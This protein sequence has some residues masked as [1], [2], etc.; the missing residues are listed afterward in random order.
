MKVAA[1]TKQGKR[2]GVVVELDDE[3]KVVAALKD[4]ASSWS[5]G[6]EDGKYLCYIRDPKVDKTNTQIAGNPLRGKFKNNSYFATGNCTVHFRD[7]KS[8]KIRQPKQMGFSIKF[9]DVLDRMGM[10]DLEVTEY[11]FT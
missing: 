4:A 10:P 3:T 1:I 5:E 11:K 7:R 2:R 8:G 6:N 9:K